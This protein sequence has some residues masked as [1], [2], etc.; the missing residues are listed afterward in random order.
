MTID[1]RYIAASL[2]G[3]SLGETPERLAKAKALAQRSNVA[4]ADVEA[5]RGEV[6]R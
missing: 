2:W 3:H 1:A 5:L 6:E 4:W